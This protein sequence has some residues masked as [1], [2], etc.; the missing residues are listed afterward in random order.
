MG[1]RRQI[2]EKRLFYPCGWIRGGARKKDAPTAIA[3]KGGEVTGWGIVAPAGFYPPRG[4][5]PSLQVFVAAEERRKGVG[6]RIV[7]RM[8]DAFGMWGKRLHIDSR[9]K[10]L[11]FYRATGFRD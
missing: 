1:W 8:L 2:A 11:A 6:T 3:V 4:K 9:K 7:H 10:A 5:H